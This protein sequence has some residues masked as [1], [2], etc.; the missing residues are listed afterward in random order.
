MQFVRVG[1]ASPF[2]VLANIYRRPTSD[3]GAFL[4]E[5]GDLLAALFVGCTDHFVLYGDLNC[6]ASC[7]QIDHHLADLR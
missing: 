7:G 2:A 5:L 3:I 4:N 1:S 6:G